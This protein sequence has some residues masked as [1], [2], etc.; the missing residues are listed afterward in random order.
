MSILYNFIKSKSIKELREQGHVMTGKLINSF[1][2]Q[3]EQ[4]PTG[5]RIKILV[6][7][8][9]LIQNEKYLVK[10]LQFSRN[11]GKNGYVSGIL[12]FAKERGLSEQVAWKIIRK[13][14]KGER[15]PMSGAS[16][17]STNGRRTGWIQQVIGERDFQLGNDFISLAGNLK[18][19]EVF[20]ALISAFKDGFARYFGS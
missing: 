1:V 12:N 16:K 11:G 5:G 8:Y 18:T 9:G 20:P 2:E 7:D 10:N 13:H 14:Y 3:N 6:Q 19:N 17:Y 4:T 15:H